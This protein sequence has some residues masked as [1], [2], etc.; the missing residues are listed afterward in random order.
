MFRRNK[1]GDN[2]VFRR[3]GRESSEQIRRDAHLHR[4]AAEQQPLAHRIGQ[5]G[6]MADAVRPKVQH[7]ERLRFIVH[8]CKVQGYRQAEDV[9]YVHKNRLEMVPFAY[10]RVPAQLDA[11]QQAGALVVRGQRE[12]AL[13]YV[14]CRPG[15]G[16][17]LGPVD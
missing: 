12:K 11:D 13:C 6:G 15:V 17:R 10:V 9:A 14:H 2:E 7:G 1:A 4:H 16:H 5:H 3:A 8:L